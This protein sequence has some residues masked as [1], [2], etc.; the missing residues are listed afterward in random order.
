MSCSLQTITLRLTCGERKIWSN[1]KKSQNIMT[2]IAVYV[3]SIG[4]TLVDF[5]LN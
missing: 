2:I 1:I 5:H 4:I 3:F